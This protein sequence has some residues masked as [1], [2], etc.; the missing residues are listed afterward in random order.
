AGVL[1]LIMI[2]TR[3]MREF[4]LVGVWAIA[5]IAARHWGEIATL[6]WTSVVWAAILIASITSH[7]YKNRHAGPFR[8][9]ITT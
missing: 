4:A 1:N 9:R 2:F 7:A 3:N 5:A 6:Q 8:E